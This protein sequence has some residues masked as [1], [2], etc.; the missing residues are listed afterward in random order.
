MCNNTAGSF[1]CACREGFAASP[2]DE[3]LCIDVDE[4]EAANG[5]CSHDCVNHDGG[6]KCLC[7]PGHRLTGDGATCKLVSKAAA[8]SC[9][10]PLRPRFGHYRCSR[11]RGSDSLYPA[12]TR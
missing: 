5:G 4:C 6:R 9:R 3:K 10:S 1:E 12:G 11:R 2:V 7:P 8:G